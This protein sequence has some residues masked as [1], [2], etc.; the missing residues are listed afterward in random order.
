[1]RSLETRLQKLERDANP[2]EAF[3]C[4]KVL[5]GESQ[6]DAWKREHGDAPIDIPGRMVVFVAHRREADAKQ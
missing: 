1:M 6:E 2:T 4:V 5:S 3:V